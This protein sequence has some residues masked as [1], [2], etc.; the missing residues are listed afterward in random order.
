MQIHPDYATSFED[1][2][3]LTNMNKRDLLNHCWK[4][5][6]SIYFTTEES[7]I[8][9]LEHKA[10]TDPVFLQEEDEIEGELLNGG[11]ISVDLNRVASKIQKIDEATSSD[12]RYRRPQE[13]GVR[14]SMI[15][16]VQWF[17]LVERG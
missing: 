13:K 5:S 1:L 12:T 16:L 9:F 4:F 3:I 14:L 7:V 11:W 10:Q 6:E 17:D 8:A 15:E 2:Q